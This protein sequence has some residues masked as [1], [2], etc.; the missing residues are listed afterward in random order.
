MVA[1]RAICCIHCSF[2]WI[3]W[4]AKA[5]ARAH[6]PETR[7][8]AF[9]FSQRWKDEESERRGAVT[10]WDEF[11]AVF[12]LYRRQFAQVEHPLSGG[13]RIDL[14][15]PKQ[16]LVEHKGRG[17]L[18]DA[19]RH[20]ALQ[21]R[22]ESDIAAALLRARTAIDVAQWAFCETILCSLGTNRGQDFSFS[23]SLTKS[24]RNC[25]FDRRAVQS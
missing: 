17:L 4:P 1:F 22:Q 13:R 20:R 21:R 24:L 14:F 15:W 12:G 7:L 16:L 5:E 10:F 25:R 8:R 6:G 23:H 11:F 2:G 18:K 19:F 9:Q 3:R